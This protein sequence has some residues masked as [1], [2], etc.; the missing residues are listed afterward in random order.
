MLERSPASRILLVAWRSRQSN[1][2]SGLIPHPLSSTAHQTLAPRWNSTSTRVARRVEAVLHEFLDHGHGAL[3][4]LAGGD[5]VG[6]A[7]G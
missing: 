5:L 7:V 4:H 2:S 1:A 3:H 6:H